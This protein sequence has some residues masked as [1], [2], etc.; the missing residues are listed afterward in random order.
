MILKIDNLSGGYN[1]RKIIE[2]INFSID[3]ASITAIIGLNGAG[4]STTIKHILGLLKPMEGKVEVKGLTLEKNVEEYRRNISYIPESPVLYDEL[5]LEEHIN[6]T[7]MAYG[8]DMKE[9]WKRA[10][11]L[12]KLFKLENK[13][14]FLPIHFSKGMKQKVMI[15]C[16][17]LV[18]P[19]LYIIDEPFLG[20]D[21]IA[22]KDLI[23][24]MT[25]E[26]EKGKS[27]LMSTHILATAE[28]YCDNFVIIHEGKIVAN[29]NLEDIRTE[30]N[31]QDAKL[32]DIYLSLTN[33]V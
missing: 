20:L 26:K 19:S 31:M 25:K 1:R 11:Y 2:N 7:A 18:E 9:A 21:P 17:F 13:K 27:I 15:I 32:D 33:Q 5:T 6:L 14:K 12:L 24:L 10:D 3:K 30:F 28:R 16:A 29:G 23:D 8:I 4:K 22:I